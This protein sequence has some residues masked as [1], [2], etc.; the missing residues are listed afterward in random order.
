MFP[1]EFEPA[2]A[3]PCYAEPMVDGAPRLFTR[4]TFRATITGVGRPGPIEER[5]GCRLVRIVDPASKEGVH[6]LRDRQVNVIGPE[7][8]T[9]GRVDLDQARQLLKTR[10]EGVLATVARDDGAEAVRDGLA[11]LRREDSRIG[12]S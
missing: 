8:T 10:L 12:P 9:L 1:R 3:Q 11:R 2:E 6:L 4:G 7:G 5:L